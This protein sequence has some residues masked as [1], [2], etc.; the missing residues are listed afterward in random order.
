MDAAYWFSV[1]LV[2]GVTLTAIPLRYLWL[3]DRA[4]LERQIAARE[5][6]ITYVK[7][8]HEA[9]WRRMQA[10]ID[11]LRLERAKALVDLHTVKSDRLNAWKE[12]NDGRV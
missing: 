2:A 7:R 8:I 12:A 10:E 9:D 11:T 1:G 4:R 3:A 5:D 6:D